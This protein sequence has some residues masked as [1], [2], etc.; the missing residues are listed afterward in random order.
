M[1]GL[2]ILGTMEMARNAMQTARQGAEIAG[3]NLANAS[4]PIYARQRVKIA[5]AVAIPTDKGPQGSGSEVARIEQIRD[6][7]IDK[8]LVEEKGVTAFLESKQRGLQMAES[9]LGQS[10]DRQSVNAGDAYSTFGISE[11]V[12]DLF[13]SFQSLSA[14]PTS[15]AERQTALYSAQK[16]TDKFKSVDR[17]LDNLRSSLNKEI[18][19][20]IVNA[21]AK[22]EQLAYL[23][24]SIGNTE[25]VEGAA[26]EIRDVMQ[27]TLEQLAE[28][29]N[30]TTSTNED[31]KMSVFIS[32]EEFITD[33]VMTDVMKVVTNGNGYHSAASASN[34]TA[35]NLTSGKIAGAI[36]ARDGG[37]V[38]LRESLNT[39]ASELITQVNGLHTTG[40]DLSGNNDNTLNFFT[41]SGAADISVNDTLKADARRLQMSG[42]A[43]EVGDN[44]I[45]RALAEKLESPTINL[46]NMSY[47]EHYGNTVSSFGQEL[48]LVNV[49]LNDQKAV[50]N[51][52]QKQ[53]DSVQGVSIDEEVANLVIF[54]RA[55]QASARLIS[56]MNTLM[57]DV[58]NM[59]R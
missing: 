44:T 53:R 4:N 35:L 56:T 16:L 18:K 19:A 57:G 48:S 15:T 23:A 17:R 21:N 2:G 33:N 1:G 59:Q 11:G 3:N 13:N 29:V 49:Q 12:T 22:L 14:S 38:D 58:I 9:S 30:L 10:L 20:D 50:Q 6:Y 34:G 42:S 47:S 7:A 25:L 8:Q 36:D 51:M 27:H 26:N 41:G 39:L 43:S 45:A 46:N 31:G 55:F 52:L 28:F 24:S 37:V 5:A 54:Q 40:Y 32:G